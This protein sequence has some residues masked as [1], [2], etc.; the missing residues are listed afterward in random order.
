MKILQIYSQLKPK[1]IFL[2]I[3]HQV[4]RIPKIGR[5]GRSLL[6]REVSTKYGARTNKIW[7]PGTA[8]SNHHNSTIG[9][10]EWLRVF[11]FEQSYIWRELDFNYKEESVIQK[12][13]IGLVFTKKIRRY[14]AKNCSAH[15]PISLIMFCPN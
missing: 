11:I 9:A 8:E 12:D 14:R 4:H 15:V 13:S 2:S 7:F 6:L 1:L 10:L 5:A 3:S